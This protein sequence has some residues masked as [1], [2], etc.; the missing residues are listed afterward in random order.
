[1]PRIARVVIPGV[2]HHIT[3]RGNRRQTTFFSDDDYRLYLKLLARYAKKHRLDIWGYC[4]MGNHV[5]QISVPAKKESLASAI[6]STHRDY[7]HA[8]NIREGWKGYLWQGRFWS[9]PLDEARLYK[10]MRYVERNPVRARIVKRAED[11]PW[12]SARAHVSGS[13]DSLLSPCPLQKVIKDWSAYLAEGD[14]EEDLEEI[15]KHE[16]TGRP[17]GDK[18]FIETLERLTS[19]A[20]LPRKPGRKKAAKTRDRQ[21]RK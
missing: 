15:R 1:M 14:S 5:H 12:S 9:F 20:L 10:G 3:Q 11:Y 6:G 21:D 16:R 19:R 8:I 2:A 18:K 7:T 4:L 13:P 17:L